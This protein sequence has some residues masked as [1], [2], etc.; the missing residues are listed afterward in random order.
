DRPHDGPDGGP[1]QPGHADGQGPAL[2]EADDQRGEQVR[3]GDGD[4]ED[5]EHVEHELETRGETGREGGARPDA[6]ERDAGPPRQGPP[7]ADAAWPATAPPPVQGT[8]R[9]AP[10]RSASDSAR[11]GSDV[12]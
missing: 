3:G 1:G 5:D 10:C 12:G 4:R 9:S 8:T 7:P 2:A 6:G 11:T